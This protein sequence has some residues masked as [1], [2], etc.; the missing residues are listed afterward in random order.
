MCHIKNL[1][2]RFQP[3]WARS[4]F[5]QIKYIYILRKLLELNR[6]ACYILD[7][8]CF[9]DTV[10]RFGYVSTVWLA[11]RTKTFWHRFP[12]LTIFGNRHSN[13]LEIHQ[14]SIQWIAASWKK[15]HQRGA[16]SARY[17]YCLIVRTGVLFLTTDL[18]QFTSIHAECQRYAF[19]LANSTSVCC[20][21]SA[22]IIDRV[23]RDP[24]FH[25]IR[26]RVRTLLRLWVLALQYYFVQFYASLCIRWSNVP[27]LTWLFVPLS[28]ARVDFLCSDI[29]N[30]FLSRQWASCWECQTD[31]PVCCITFFA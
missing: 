2:I 12:F 25:A 23:H 22:F 19:Q 31:R 17:G 4:W 30:Y 5:H 9:Q 1:D 29:P 28:V 27:V 26:R 7:F 8:L 15:F 21:S 3:F 13:F 11:V 24:L 18:R 10:P 20:C 16:V 6:L 14:T